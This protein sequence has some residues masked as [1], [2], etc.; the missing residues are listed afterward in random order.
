M[1]DYRRV[2]GGEAK[3]PPPHVVVVPLGVN[4]NPF[5]QA[6]NRLG[7]AR[8]QYAFRC[9]APATQQNGTPNAAG[10]S[11]ASAIAGAVAMYLARNGWASRI[12]GGDRFATGASQENSTSGP[13]EDPDTKDPIVVVTGSLVATAQAV[14]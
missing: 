6:S 9:V 13:I 14:G 1:A 12:V 3:I 7:L 4:P 8:H 5:G 10:G 2:S 11:Q